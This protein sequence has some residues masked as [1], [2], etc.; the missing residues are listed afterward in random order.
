MGWMGKIVGGTIGLALG[1]PLGAI[2]GAA[3]GHFFD[4]T[5]ELARRGGAQGPRLSTHEDAQMT[6][7]V[8]AFS[9]LAKLVQADGRVTQ[10]EIATIERFMRD[11]LRLSPASRQV[12]VNIFNTAKTSPHAFDD[13]ALQFHQAFRNRPEILAFMLDILVRVSLADQDFST[14]EAELV[15]RAARIFGLPEPDP[16]K[17]GAHPGQ[18]QDRF[19][20][21]L[22]VSPDA[23]D[24]EIKKHYRTLVKEFHPDRIAAKGLPD[25]FTDFAE[26]KFREIQ[27]AYEAVKKARGIS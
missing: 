23:S 16:L 21:T 5:N 13:F 17:A 4:Q 10:D 11:D 18:A 12:A 24:E 25:E 1:G 15:R 7:F 6:F 26:S 19:Y 27:E 14:A 8:A 22:G 20:R 3:F 9:M 2:A